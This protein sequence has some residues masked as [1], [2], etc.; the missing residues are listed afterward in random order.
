MTDRP[1]LTAADGHYAID[2]SEDGLFDVYCMLWPTWCVA[3][4]TTREAAEAALRLLS[5]GG[6]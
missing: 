4:C 2:E 6:R 3:A 5:G 1:P